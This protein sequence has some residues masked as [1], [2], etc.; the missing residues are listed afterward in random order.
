MSTMQTQNYRRRQDHF[1]PEDM[2]P[3]EQRRLRGMLEQVDY[4]AY[5]ANREVISATLGR[6]TIED[7]S[8]MAAR[9][10]QAR[11]RWL[12]EGLRLAHSSAASPD[13]YKR[14]NEA[15][16][17]YEEMAQLFEG[18]R[19]ACERGYLP[20]PATAPQSGPPRR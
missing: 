4:S 13:Q 12:A 1:Q 11:A 17:A 15:R 20:L 2:D 9:T 8:Q 7:F 3:H 14:L 6:V 18:I 16:M 19:R 5:V 10:A